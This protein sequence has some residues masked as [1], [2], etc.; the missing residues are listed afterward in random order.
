MYKKDDLLVINVPL[1]NQVNMNMRIFLVVF[2]VLGSHLLSIG[3]AVQIDEN[4]MRTIETENTSEVFIV[5]NAQADVSQ[6][7]HIRK[8]SAKGAFVFK[9]LQAF[10]ARSQQDII[11]WLQSHGYHYQSLVVANGVF[12]QID[13]KALQYLRT[14][15]D[16]KAIAANPMIPLPQSEKVPNSVLRNKEL[17]AWGISKI[18]AQNVWDLGIR[19]AGIVVGGQDTG[20]DHLHPVISRK[21]RGYIDSVSFDHAYNWHDA[22]HEIDPIHG[23]SIISSENNPC[24]LDSPIP[25]D[26]HSH[27]TH[28]VGTMVGETEDKV[29]GIA[30]DAEWI[31][32]RCMERG[33]GTPFTY[34][35]CFE[36][37][38]APTDE[39]G[40]NPDPDKAPHVINNS[41]GCPPMEGCNATNFDLI[42][43]AI[44]NL[45]AAGI[46]VV[47]SAG[48]EG[49]SGCGT[50]NDP[51]AMFDGALAVGASDIDDSLA[52]FSSRGPVLVDG[53]M[54]M[55]P[56]V[57]APGVSIRSAV[58]GGGTASWSGTSMAGPHVAGAVALLIS[59]VPDLAGQ[60]EVIEDLLES[61][62]IPLFLEDSCGGI[63]GTDSPN[64]FFGYGR[65]D[66]LAAVQKALDQQ[67]SVTPTYNESSVT[68]FPNPTRSYIY[69]QFPEAPTRAIIHIYNEIGQQV[70]THSIPDHQ[71]IQ[72][73]DIQQLPKG[74]YWI[75]VYGEKTYRP[76]K[77]IKM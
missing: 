17:A 16:V 56:N 74:I 62:A 46:V 47:A 1:R 6:A 3:Q 22:I 41:W 7:K 73:I 66:V 5:M 31:G 50:V 27:G 48:N 40:L 45:R 71:V 32:C 33:Y 23:D 19:G 59:A 42:D 53:S 57:V 25:C 15:S 63:A 35:E 64:P 9:T 51:P 21:Y 38:L 44:N 49:R 70:H 65:I 68:L 29:Y 14:R 11:Q 2:T 60:V 76:V 67:T 28:T 61:T 24:G 43:E 36:W 37:F 26:D 55:K 75:R 13:A 52:A 77:M 72:K 69:L 30:P 8:K 34:L 58:L 10:N 39:N 4:V 54:R 12:A 20:Y 18:N